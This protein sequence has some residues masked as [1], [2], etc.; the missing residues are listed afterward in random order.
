MFP[1]FCILILN[2]SPFSTRYS[3][4]GMKTSSLK[5]NNL[6]PIFFIAFIINISCCHIDG[7]VPRRIFLF[8]RGNKRMISKL[9]FY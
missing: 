2:T 6:P 7:H 4:D 1:I 9:T 5:T 3:T 8:N